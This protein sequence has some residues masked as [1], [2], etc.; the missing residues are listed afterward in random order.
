MTGWTEHALAPFGVEVRGVDLAQPW[1]EGLGDRLKVL[2]DRHK[3]ILLRGQTLSEEQQAEFCALFGP[4]LG[5][6]GE[7]RQLSSD[8]NLGSG[9]LAWHSDLAFTEEPFEAISLLATEVNDGQSWTAFADGTRHLPP[10]LSERA[11]GREALTV[12]SMIQ[13]HRAVGYDVPPYLPQH[14]RPLVIPHPRTGEDVL[15]ISE[16][17]TARVEG[18]PREESDS[19]LAELFAHL[20]ASG[21]VYRHHWRNGDLVLWDNI[22]LAHSRC[23]LTGMHPR[24]MQRICCARRSF[25][26]ILPDF[27]LDDP[28][29]AAWGRGEE[30]VLD[31]REGHD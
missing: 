2:R 24:R 6:T 3:L 1:P 18:L 10:G 28:R 11:A 9:P 23:D 31:P 30:L 7:Y 27:T 26:E 8:G 13:T 25:F 14:V 29:I 12:I 20:Y 15:Y 4:V 19:L 17:Q 5:A 21:N 16:M 22:A